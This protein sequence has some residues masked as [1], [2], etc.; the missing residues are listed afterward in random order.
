MF[1]SSNDEHGQGN[2]Y[3]TD[4]AMLGALGFGAPGQS[5]S[6]QPMGN[7]Q[8]AAQT[9]GEPMGNPYGNYGNLYGGR[10]TA[11]IASGPATAVAKPPAAI[12]AT[13]A[14][15]SAMATGTYTPKTP[16]KVIQQAPVPGGYVPPYQAIQPA[17]WW[18]TDP[19]QMAAGGGEEAQDK[20]AAQAQQSGGSG[21]TWTR[22]LI[23][24]TLVGAAAGGYYYWKKSKGSGGK[25]KRE[26]APE[27]D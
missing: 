27:E 25:K 3:I 5:G 19:A 16:M 21:I 14:A 1:G 6:S 24:L 26:S 18:T 10:R 7:M 20:R 11:T 23:G 22:V 9:Y 15:V 8:F 2:G 17:F 4:Q 13:N 12:Q